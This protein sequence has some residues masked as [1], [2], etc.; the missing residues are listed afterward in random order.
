ML[1]CCAISTK[2]GKRAISPSSFRISQ[3]TLAGSRLAS[4]AK[5]QPAS[6]WPART[7]TPPLIALSGNTC[8][9][10]TMLL[11]LAFLAIA[12][13]TVV[14]RSAAEIPVVTPLAA[15]I[16]I[17]KLVPKREPLFSTIGGKSNCWHFA[18]VSVRQIKPRPCLAIKL[19]CSALANSAAMT[20]SPSFSRFSSSTKI[21]ILPFLMSAMMSV[22]GLM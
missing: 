15:S 4:A 5:S 14:A 7:N 22:I 20:K 21:T 2:S 17:V 10:L 12:A 9:G 13:F 8:P 6:V 3:I 16:D 18:S 19:M 1:C 11:A